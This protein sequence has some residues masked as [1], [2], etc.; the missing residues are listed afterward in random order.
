MVAK[1]TNKKT[2]PNNAKTGSANS[3]KTGN[4]FAKNVNNLKSKVAQNIKVNK[5]DIKESANM[6]V[7]FLKSLKMEYVG[8]QITKMVEDT[9]NIILSP[10][11]F[12]SSIKVNNDFSAPVKTIVAF[13]LVAGALSI[14]L[15]FWKIGLMG[16]I[17]TIIMYP[18]LILMASFC[19]AGFLLM[20]SCIT[21]GEM[22]FER[23]FKIVASQ[24]FLF[25]IGAVLYKLMPAWFL[26]KTASIAMDF[27]VVL[28]AYFSTVYG[29]K[30]KE[31]LAQITFGSSFILLI[32]FY[33]S[34]SSNVW[35]LLK[36][37]GF[38]L[39]VFN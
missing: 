31:K 38:A 23:A 26:M 22:N 24:V 39:S 33:T 36:N 30:G 35:V 2:K 3:K 37:P 7:K 16:A 32:L 12:F 15:S 21:K 4:D 18:F 34:A 20:F 1:K 17:T 8:T 6:F 29:L 9:K 25:P 5:K 13:G 11:K 14:L 27:Y 10:V 28:L 19:L